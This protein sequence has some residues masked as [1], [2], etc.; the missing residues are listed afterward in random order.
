MSF[1]SKIRGTFETIFSI[2][3][4][5]RVQLKNSAGVL[6]IRDAADAAVLITRGLA[7]V[8][9]DDYVTKKHFDDNNSAATGLTLVEM[10]L[11]LATKVSTSTIPDS[12]TIEY[13]Y[14]RIETAYDAAALWK[15]QRTGDATVEPVADGDN[16]ASVIGTYHVPQ[17]DTNW[18]VTGAGTVNAVLTNSPTVGAATLVIAYSMPNDIS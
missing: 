12:S 10:P 8:G 5:N 16:D 4:A 6:E 15:I 3:K 1:F 17:D 7:P 2:G 14:I 18:G 13:A 11:L 9:D